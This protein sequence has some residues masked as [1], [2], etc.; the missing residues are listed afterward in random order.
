VDTELRIAVAAAILGKGFPAAI[1]SCLKKHL[2]PGESI[3]ETGVYNGEEREIDTARLWKLLEGEPKP[4]ALV[5]ICVRLDAQVLAPFHALGAPV[6]LIDEEATGASTVAC[7]NA[8]GGY[9][10][11]Q[12]LAMLGRRSI[13]VVSGPLHRNGSYNAVRRVQGFAKA[14][15]EHGVP[16]SE[17]DVIEVGYYSHKDGVNVMTRLLDERRRVDAVFCAAGDATATGMMAVA[18]RRG[19]EIPGQLAIVGYDDSP[20]AAIATPPLTSIRQSPEQFAAEAYALATA[21]RAEC[22]ARPKR[23]IFAPQLVIRESA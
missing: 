20:L 13:A 7:D 11:G 18:R 15:A 17:R 1:Y 10:A 19:I 23:V 8:A 21:R 5:G 16:F 12:H 4:A 6:I 2:K 9:M 14:C 3:V 22:L